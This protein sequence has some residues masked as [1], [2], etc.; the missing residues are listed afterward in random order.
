M[1]T[2]L[3]SL[4]LK[5]QGI[6]EQ[7]IY[8]V[9]DLLDMNNK[10]GQSYISVDALLCEAEDAEEIT[11][12]C[13]N[14]APHCKDDA[15]AVDLEHNCLRLELSSGYMVEIDLPFSVSQ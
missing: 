2:H 7:V 15:L 8:L 13:L 5:S 12:Y 3:L 9:N 11:C 14:Y 6:D 10:D 4:S 1:N